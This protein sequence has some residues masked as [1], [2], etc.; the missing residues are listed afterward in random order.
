[1]AGSK[2]KN[3]IALPAPRDED[4]VGREFL[5]RKH[6]TLLAVKVS[7]TSEEG[8]AIF[9]LAR[10]YIAG[11]S[12]PRDSVKVNWREESIQRQLAESASDFER[13]IREELEEAK[14]GMP[15]DARSEIEASN[16][17]R[18][19]RRAQVETAG[20]SVKEHVEVGHP[21]KIA[22]AMH[23]YNT[24]HD[25]VV[26]GRI[27][28]LPEDAARRVGDCELKTSELVTYLAEKGIEWPY[29]LGTDIDSGGNKHGS[30]PGTEGDDSNDYKMVRQVKWIEDATQ[31]LIEG[32]STVP[33]GTKRRLREQALKHNSL[34]RSRGVFDSAWKR[35]NVRE[36]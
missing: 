7:P 6:A 18:L 23:V 36:K 13:D 14:R 11:D 33:T 34:F 22:E 28:V 3:T 4:F 24:I 8:T 12:D 15:S 25:G 10:E 26:S 32:E 31:K 35:A 2:S 19:N 20:D 27:T 1:M 9:E 16:R 30:S 5:S 21:D 29:S 17:E